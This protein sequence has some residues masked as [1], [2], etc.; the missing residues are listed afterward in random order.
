MQLITSTNHRS[1]SP[2]AG[3]AV[4]V[5]LLLTSGFAQGATSGTG[6]VQADVGQL[7]EVSVVD[8]SIA[9][10]SEFTPTSGDETVKY[11]TAD[12]L[13]FSNAKSNIQELMH[14][15]VGVSFVKDADGSTS[16]STIQYQGETV[17]LSDLV[18]LAQSSAGNFLPW[19]LT[20]TDL[21]S[22]GNTGWTNH[23]GCST[24]NYQGSFSV[25]YYTNGGAA[26]SAL[27]QYYRVCDS[28]EIYLGSS[29][30]LSSSDLANLYTSSASG[31][32]AT[33]EN[34]E[35]TIQGVDYVF[36]SAGAATSVTLRQGQHLALGTS[37]TTADVYALL[38]VPDGFP[39][40]VLSVTVTGTVADIVS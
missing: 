7:I 34:Y 29:R 10:Y 12:S 24:S 6:T 27:T 13:R 11:S 17:T 33:A 19:A 4:L 1:R 40:G 16:S 5:G 32:S 38:K 36:Y 14:Y 18:Y 30:D 22:E 15:G 3:I 37:A 25:P 9:A 35:V 28:N 8:G 21:S 39:A 20:G 31:P 23:A 2:R 26:V